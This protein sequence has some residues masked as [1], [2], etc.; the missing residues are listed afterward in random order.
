M[1][2]LG[3]SGSSVIFF[4]YFLGVVVYKGVCVRGVKLHFVCIW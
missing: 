3:D 2:L 4:L 1:Y